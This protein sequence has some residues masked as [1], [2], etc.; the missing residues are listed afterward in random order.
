MEEKCVVVGWQK[1]KTDKGNDGI[2]L[3][4]TRA[5]PFDVDGEG[6]E[7]LRF[8]INPEYCKYQPKLGD[9]IVIIEGRYPGSVERVI[10]AA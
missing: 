8:Y 7:T 5:L 6:V 4:V 3:Y 1:V 10:N 9:K 2:R